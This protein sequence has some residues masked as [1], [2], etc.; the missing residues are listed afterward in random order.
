VG[1]INDF[2][3]VEKIPDPA[4]TRTPTPLLFSPYP[5]AIPT[6]LSRLPATVVEL[7]INDKLDRIWKEVVVM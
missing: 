2:G 6:E 7:L 1:P 5:V 4:R 3:D